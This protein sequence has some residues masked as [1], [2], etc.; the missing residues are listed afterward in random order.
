MHEV[1]RLE[2]SAPLNWR[3]ERGELKGRRGA[4]RGGK[5]TRCFWLARSHGLARVLGSVRGGGRELVVE[6]KLSSIE[7][8]SGRGRAGPSRGSRTKRSWIR[9]LIA[10]FPSKKAAEI[11]AGRQRRQR[12]G[13][14]RWREE[15]NASFQSCWI[16]L[17]PR[18]RRETQR[19]SVAHPTGNRQGEQRVREPEAHVL[20]RRDLIENPRDTGART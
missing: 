3:C 9:R 13:L 12:L 8:V 18:L 5:T 7:G 1:S 11:A 4:H 6:K 10:V 19:G 2:T 16:R 15:E 17:S 20:A 14:S